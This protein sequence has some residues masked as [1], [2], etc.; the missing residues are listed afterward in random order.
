MQL[1]STASIPSTAA[2]RVPGDPR[3]AADLL[4][5]TLPVVKHSWLVKDAAELPTVLEE[6]LYVAQTGRPGPVLN[7]SGGNSHDH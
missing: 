2:V 5:I 3:L 7:T 4:N 6:A 1:A